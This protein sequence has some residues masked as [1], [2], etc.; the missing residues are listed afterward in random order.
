MLKK[1][2]SVIGAI[3]LMLGI[4]LN[5]RNSL[6]NY[7]IVSNSLSAYVLAQNQS[8]G[9]DSSNPIYEGRVAHKVKVHCKITITTGSSQGSSSGVSG[10]VSVGAG[11]VGVGGSASSGSSTGSSTSTEIVKEFDAEKVL[12]YPATTDQTCQPTSPCKINY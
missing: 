10:S 2:L 9:G 8:S 4:G 11:G 12:Y 6:N 3:A 1:F 7:G 5:V